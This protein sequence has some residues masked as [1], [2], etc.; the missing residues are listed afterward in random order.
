MIRTKQELNEYIECDRKRHR[1]PKLNFFGYIVWKLRLFIGVCSE[2][3]C[4]VNYLMILR[5][6]EY[7]LNN[8]SNNYLFWI[9]SK[10][11]SLHHKR[12]SFKYGIYIKPNTV[13]KGL[14]IPHFA[15][16]INC[17]CVSMGDYC[18]ISTGVV[19]GNK[20]K[21]ENRPTIGNGVELTIGC[22]V[23]GK[24]K[25]GDNAIVAPNSVVI[26]DVPANAIVSGVPAKILRM[27]NNV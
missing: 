3:D 8:S 16:G 22:K 11:Y 20:H 21:Q 2:T 24:V 18:I 4:S 1:K 26:H 7:Y 19:L 23:I 25:I 17:N 10:Y 5:K 27:R 12:L 14:Y 6:Y 9:I 15:G 13:G